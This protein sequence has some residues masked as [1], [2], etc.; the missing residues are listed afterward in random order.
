MFNPQKPFNELPLLPPKINFDDIKLLKLVNKANNSL[1]ELKGSAHILPNRLILL[2]PLSIREAVASSGVENINTTVSEALK[3]DVLF[4]KRKISGA[5]KETLHYR[6]AL[7]HGFKLLN[8]QGFLSVN[9][10]IEIQSIL[11]ANKKG[12]RKIPGVKIV[13]QKTGEIM[14]TPPE[15]FE[16]I[17][18]KLKNFEEYFNDQSDFDNL[19]PLV[20]LAVLHY[21]FEAIHPFLDGN[22]RTGRILMV[23]YL[24]M[25][26]RLDLPIL[27][28]SKFILENRDEYYR[29]L[30]NIS[31]QEAWKEWVIYILQAIDTQAKTTHRDILKIKKLIEKYKKMKSKILT[32][33][34]LDYLFSNPFYSQAA[35][36]A[37]LNIHRNTA[38]KYFTELEKLGIV[39]KF[40]HKQANVYYN[41]EFLDI[42][43]Y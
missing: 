39:K 40:K 29:L 41:Q 6:D 43:S 3:A 19:D 27:F 32:P 1:F 4:D 20:R 33:R 5:E 34:F 12:I 21:Q 42:L 38:S 14:Y 37:K 17:N 9:S 8:K 36:S 13:N 7:M 18:K 26:G 2:S 11:E 24:V 23:L 30:N 22:G 31:R 10:F 15:G 35:L 16:T 25:V 28:L